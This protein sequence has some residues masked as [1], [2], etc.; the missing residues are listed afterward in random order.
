MHTLYRIAFL[1]LI[2][3]SSCTRTQVSL[4]YK[5]REGAMRLGQPVMAVGQFENRRREGPYLLGV[6]TT[7][8]GTPIELLEMRVPVEEAVHNAFLHALNAR[9]M[10]APGDRAKFH[11][12]GE[13]LE[14]SC[15][16]IS[17]PYAIARLR[18]NLVSG[19]N[20]RILFSRIF[21]AERQDAS[22]YTAQGNST[23][24]LRELAS[25]ALQDAVD[26]AIDDAE[27][28]GRMSGEQKKR[29]QR[30]ELPNRIDIL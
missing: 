8:L 17:R 6:S 1:A 10:L 22:Y 29:Y 7:P 2:G 26:H 9:G 23:S 15:R 18:V 5:P 27:L 24:V 20:G 13:I 19:A 30:Y 4:D 12:S 25:R 3:L 21:T 14:L 16:Q 28:R 11:L